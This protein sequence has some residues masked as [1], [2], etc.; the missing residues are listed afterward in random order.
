MLGISGAVSEVRLRRTNV[1][2]KSAIAVVV[3]L[4]SQCRAVLIDGLDPSL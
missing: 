4:E 3:V 2:G 1:D